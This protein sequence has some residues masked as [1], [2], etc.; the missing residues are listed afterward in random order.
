MINPRKDELLSE[1]N[2]NQRLSNFKFVRYMAAK[3]LPFL[4][5]KNVQ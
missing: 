1:R 3:E 5:G 4:I 2:R